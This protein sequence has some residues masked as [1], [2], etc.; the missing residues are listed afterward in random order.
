MYFTSFNKS[1][2]LYHFH[3][4]PT[5][6]AHFDFTMS[7]MDIFSYIWTLPSRWVFFPPI[8]FYFTMVMI[9]CQETHFALK[10]AFSKFFTQ[11]NHCFRQ[12]INI[13][14]IGLWTRIM[15]N[16]ELFT[17]R[18]CDLSKTNCF[19]NFIMLDLS[20][21]S[22]SMQWKSNKRHKFWM[23]MLLGSL[24]K[25]GVPYIHSFVHPA[26]CNLSEEC[27]HWTG[28]KL[29]PV[30][31]RPLLLMGLWVIA[32]PMTPPVGIPPFWGWNPTP[33]FIGV[34]GFTFGQRKTNEAAKTKLMSISF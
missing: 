9:F 26:I 13:L 11:R 25:H 14:Q 18:F 3:L 34:L 10:H 5:F 8:F 31:C 32:V 2:E 4:V 20:T 16:G 21:F 12:H 23:W 30:L 7:T 28:C 22:H 33:T 24:A 6:D 17:Y 19:I 15:L 29:C 1:I 27:P